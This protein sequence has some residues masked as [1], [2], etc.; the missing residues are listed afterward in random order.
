MSKS[1]ATITSKSTK[2]Q[3]LVHIAS[4]D[5]ALLAQGHTIRALRDE[6]SMAQ[7]RPTLPLGRDT[8]AAYYRYVAEQRLVA[9]TAGLRVCSYKTYAQWSAA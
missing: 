7:S 4:Q 2:A 1:L 5:A 3:L 6:L 9:R 8:H